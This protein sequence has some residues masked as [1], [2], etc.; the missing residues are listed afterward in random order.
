ML[1]LFHFDEEGANSGHC[2]M[3]GYNLVHKMKLFIDASKLNFL[4]R[5]Y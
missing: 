1:L 3:K 2:H 4:V 5:S